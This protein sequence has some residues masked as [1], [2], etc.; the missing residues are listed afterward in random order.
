M[1]S[2]VPRYR[3]A[4]QVLHLGT[5]NGGTEVD[6]V[7]RFRPQQTGTIG[8]ALTIPFPGTSAGRI[9]INVPPSIFRPYSF[10]KARI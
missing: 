9:G 5:G 1:S 3:K 7:A 10:A 2:D 6:G 8:G 4:T